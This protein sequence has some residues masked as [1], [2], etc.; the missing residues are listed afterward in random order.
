MLHVFIELGKSVRAVEKQVIV[1]LFPNPRTRLLSVSPMH[2]TMASRE[3]ASQCHES[4]HWRRVSAW[5][6]L[7]SVR[8]C[9][10]EF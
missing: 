2:H 1:P 9:L 6:Y 10:D 3:G 5:T 8:I 7:H 4:I